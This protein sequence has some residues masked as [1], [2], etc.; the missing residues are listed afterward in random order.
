MSSQIHASAIIDEGSIIGSQTQVWHFCHIMA[1]ASI[2]SGCILGQNV[3]V[4]STAVIG[5]HVK[6]QNNVSI[7]DGVILEDDVF[8]GPSVVFTKVS[9]PRSFISQKSSYAP[10]RVCKGAS[11]GANATVICG[12][13]IG[14]YAMIGAGAV[15]TTSVPAFALMT[16]NPARH[17]G[18]VSMTGKPLDI[19]E[20]E[21]IYLPEEGVSYLLKDKA[22][23]LQ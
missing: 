3:F 8:V 23:A 7:Y 2:G 11:L 4:A 16:G 13:V 14:E 5:N 18:W 19:A 21:T 17:V 12:V 9:R 1:G 10:T 20:G 6:I 15:I 22:L